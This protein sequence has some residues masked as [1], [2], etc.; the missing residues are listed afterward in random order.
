MP[1]FLSRRVVMV[2][3]QVRPSD[4]T[5]FPIIEAMLRI[6]RERFVP[7]DRVEAAYVGENLELTSG[8]V[9]LEPR[10]LAKM[11]DAITLRDSDLVLDLAC[12]TGYSS[13]V[14]G[15]IAQ[16]VVAVEG[17][18]ALAA[19]AQAALSAVEADN[20]VLVHAAPE[21]GHPA[22]APY[23]AILVQGGIEYFPQALA[24]QLR[25]GGR[26]AAVFMAGPLGVVRIGVKRDG[27]IAW[28]DAF[29]AGAPVLPAFAKTP[30]F[31]F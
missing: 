7:Q 27:R 25:E 23:D 8:R 21:A 3:T 17:D 22:A 29:N 5:K 15:R 19:E 11:I 24:D 30:A 26:V 2:D 14:M 1:D 6:P 12:G 31:S 13:A 28:R 10:T 9:L 18:G 20:V 4:V 16:V